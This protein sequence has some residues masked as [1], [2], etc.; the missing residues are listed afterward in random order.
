MKDVNKKTK[1]CC[2]TCYI[3]GEAFLFKVDLVEVP[4][5]VVHRRVVVHGLPRVHL[6]RPGLAGD[7]VAAKS[8]GVARGHAHA[9]RRGKARGFQPVGCDR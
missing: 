6:R 7:W 5:G 4:V 3:D 9:C 1:C 8:R 2:H